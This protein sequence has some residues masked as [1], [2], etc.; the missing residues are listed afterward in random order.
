MAV[1]LEYQRVYSMADYLE[2]PMVVH[3]EL[4]KV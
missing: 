1:H 4:L 2:H 3:L